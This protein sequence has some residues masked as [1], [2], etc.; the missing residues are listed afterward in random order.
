M[1]SNNKKPSPYHRD[2]LKVTSKLIDSSVSSFHDKQDC[3]FCHVHLKYINLAHFIEHVL[4][5]NV[6]FTLQLLCTK[7]NESWLF[8]KFLFHLKRW[9]YLHRSKLT[10][11]IK[12]Y[13]DEI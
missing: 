10:T 7:I 3:Q 2:V 1:V 6:I 9:G 11:I 13:F 8:I 12:V 4:R 5:Q